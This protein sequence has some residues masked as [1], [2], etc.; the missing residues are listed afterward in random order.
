MSSSPTDNNPW[1]STQ[2]F[3]SP[4]QRQE[5]I[6]GALEH[7]ELTAISVVIGLIVALSLALLIR[8]FPAF[9]GLVVG[10]SDAIYAIPSIALF[11]LLLPFTGLSII[12]PIIGLA[13]YT[14]LIL[15][16]SILEGLRS[17]SPDAIE[18]ANGLGYGPVRRLLKVELPLAL[19]VIFSGIRVATVSTV[20]LLTVAFALSHGGLGQ[21]LTLGY[22]NNLYKQQVLDA[23]L[24]IIV[25][26]VGF[27]LLIQLTARLATP[28]TRRTGRATA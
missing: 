25:I 16:R 19:P 5:Y 7:I 15:V 10:L 22:S 8:R 18:A 23:V 13:L 28:W 3:Q 12:G 17:V 9:E 4:S 11:S 24:G 1:F 6:H 14:Q 2:Y 21:V 26:A 27:D 20:G